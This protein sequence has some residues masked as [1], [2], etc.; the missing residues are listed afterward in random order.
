MLML[1]LYFMV[2]IVDTCKNFPDLQKLSGQHC[3][4]ADGVFVTLC[5]IYVHTCVFRVA[6][7]QWITQCIV[8]MSSAVLLNHCSLSFFLFYWKFTLKWWLTLSRVLLSFIG[9][10]QFAIKR[11][12]ISLTQGIVR[13]SHQQYVSCILAVLCSAVFCCLFFYSSHALVWL[14]CSDQYYSSALYATRV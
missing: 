7:R 1:W 2:N 11:P 12:Y 9:F 13:M 4:C 8:V 10:D 6:H 5:S 14:N 3:W